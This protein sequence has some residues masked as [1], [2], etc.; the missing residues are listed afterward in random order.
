MAATIEDLFGHQKAGPLSIWTL[1]SLTRL[2]FV[3]VSDARI[4]GL[5][6]PSF[7]KNK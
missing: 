4:D 6:I 1:L 2:A 5:M 7:F 3:A